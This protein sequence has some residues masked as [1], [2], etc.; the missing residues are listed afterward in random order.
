MERNLG[1]FHNQMKE[2]GCE[3]GQGARSAAGKMCPP[4]ISHQ[5]FTL[6]VKA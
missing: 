2:F 6:T 1:S 4:A 5:G 3:Q